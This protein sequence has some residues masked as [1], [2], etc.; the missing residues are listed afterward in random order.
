MNVRL[1]HVRL[2]V[3]TLVVVKDQIAEN[4]WL[5]RPPLLSNA[6]LLAYWNALFN[7][8]LMLYKTLTNI[9]LKLFGK[10]H[11]LQPT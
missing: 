10:C 3:H 4:W 6:F 11:Y 5:S 7:K 1:L 2:A 8:V 9:Y